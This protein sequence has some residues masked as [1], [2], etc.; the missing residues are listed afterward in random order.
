MGSV[1]SCKCVIIVIWGTLNIHVI[2]YYLLV[3]HSSSCGDAEDGL[4]AHSLV[5]NGR[6]DIFVV[7]GL[8]DGLFS[9]TDSPFVSLL[10]LPAFG[11]SC[12]LARSS[13][14]CLRIP[15]CRVCVTPDDQSNGF[16]SCYNVSADDDSNATLSCTSL[17]GVL[18]IENNS[19][20]PNTFPLSCEDFQSCGACLSTDIALEL[21]CVWCFCE[22]RCIAPS[23][24]IVNCPDCAVI[25]ST[26]PDICILDSCSIPSS[27]ADCKSQRGCEWLSRRIRA[28]PNVPYQFLVFTSVPEFGCYST[29]LHLEFLNK[30]GQDHSVRNCPI[31]CGAATSCSTCVALSSP[32]AGDS[33]TCLWAGYSQECLSSDLVPLACS[34]GDCGPILSTAEQCPSPC[35]SRS[36]ACEVCLMDPSCVWLSNVANGVPRCVDGRDL[37]SGAVNQTTNEIAVYLGECSL[38]IPCREFC[39]GNSELCIEEGSSNSV[40]LLV[41]P[42]TFA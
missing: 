1:Y 34:L 37:R 36:G 20:C 17:G 21:G 30:L 9:S 14:Q 15:G 11:L 19:T 42:C 26:Q 4:W 5:T 23:N 35:V 41:R 22:G 27:C 31:P 38:S 25:N 18:L 33:Q 32:T 6:G 40:S 8:T 16:I 24:S 39:H 13:A 7:G 29:I 10:H 3:S 2:I 28:N 12:S